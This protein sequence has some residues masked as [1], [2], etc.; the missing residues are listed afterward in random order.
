MK[1]AMIR[2]VLL[3]GSCIGLIALARIAAV[4]NYVVHAHDVESIEQLACKD[5]NEL[6]ARR[7]GRLSWGDGFETGYAVAALTFAR[8][9]HETV[10]QLRAGISERCAGMPH[11]TIM[12]ATR[13]VLS[14]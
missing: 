6:E 11:G 9:R 14:Q 4:Q 3:L 2:S 5:W 1:A 13:S 10:A 7:K 8:H 12:D